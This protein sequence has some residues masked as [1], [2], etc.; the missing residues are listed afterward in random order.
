MEQLETKNKREIGIVPED[1]RVYFEDYVYTYLRG[2]QKDQAA[3]LTGKSYFQ[4]GAF[5]VSVTGAIVCPSINLEEE[6]LCIS[7]RAWNYIYQ[8]LHH[9][10]ERQEIVG[11]YMPIPE[12]ADAKTFEKIQLLHERDFSGA[13]MVFFCRN[14]ENG[15]ESFFVRREG[16]LLK[17][18]GYY[19]YYEKNVQMREYI[20]L[21]REEKQLEADLQAE[22]KNGERVVMRY[23]EYMNSQQTKDRRVTAERKQKASNSLAYVMCVMAL[24]GMFLLSIGIAAG[25][26]QVNEIE[27]VMSLV[28]NE[29]HLDLTED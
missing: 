26:Q 20:M 14:E 16:H 22:Q 6:E 9:S 25:Y 2:E 21:K 29:L 13:D 24:V 8:E 15:E 10:F 19:I 11:W 4:D 7:K 23:R 12:N 1:M 3:I 5:W 18:P 17:L 28:G 27:D